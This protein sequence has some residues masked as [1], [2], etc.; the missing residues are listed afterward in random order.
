M[1]SKSYDMFLLNDKF[2]IPDTEYS[3]QCWRN[4]WGHCWMAHRTFQSTAGC[5]PT[6]PAGSKRLVLLLQIDCCQRTPPWGHVA[7]FFFFILMESVQHLKIMNSVLH[8]RFPHFSFNFLK[9]NLKSLLKWKRTH[10][11]FLDLCHLMQRRL[12]LLVTYPWEYG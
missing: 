7:T 9:C 10:E 2:S 8:F 11:V 3:Q 1:R 12:T 4:P 6:C 5:F